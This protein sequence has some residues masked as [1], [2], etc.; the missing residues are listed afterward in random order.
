[1]ALEL[2][3]VFVCAG[4]GA[5]EAKA[6]VRFGL[7]EGTPGRHPGQGTANR[8][9]SFENAM[10][11]LLWV[12]DPVEAQSE[13][14]RRTLL[15]ERWS[16]RAGGASPFGIC[17]RPTGARDE[18]FVFR[19]WEYRP[20]YLPEPLVM[21]IGEAGIEEPLWV[22]LGFAKRAERQRWFEGHAAGVR[23]ITGVTVTSPRAIESL[24]AQQMM[25]S[26][27]LT[28]KAGASS[29]LEIEFDGGRRGGR[30]DFRPELP[31]VFSF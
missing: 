11:E 3:H 8:R 12:S 13:R 15:W 1:M 17:A 22:Y 27:V 4:V 26:G 9:F 23:E 30:E 24:V 28:A 7:R 20:A 21:H 31:L 18:G 5:P 6:L 14:T 19:G 29:L 2:D 25:A 10:L 16:G